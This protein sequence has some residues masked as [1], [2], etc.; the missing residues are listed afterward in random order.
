MTRVVVSPAAGDDLLHIVTYLAT[1][2]G[3][4]IADKWDRKVW[5]AIEDVAAYPG[6]GAPRP[7][8]GDNIR[9][10]PVLPYVV[11][12]EHVRGSGVLHL[13]R[14]VHGRRHAS[15]DMLTS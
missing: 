10:I 4:V 11:I 15:K 12:Y 13:L 6:S 14:I 1:V 5:K 7:A 2:A 3:P 9:I 8:L